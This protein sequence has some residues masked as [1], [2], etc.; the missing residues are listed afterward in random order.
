MMLK[1]VDVANVLDEN[2][3]NLKKYLK[4]LWEG[5]MDAT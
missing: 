1:L 5:E 4:L 3:Q 2:I